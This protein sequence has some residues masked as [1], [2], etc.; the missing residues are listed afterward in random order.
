MT[1]P[2]PKVAVV[3]AGVAGLTAA[4]KLQHDCEVSLFEK[5][6]YIGGHTRTLTV[7]DGPDRGTP[8]D[9]GFIVMNHRN[10]PHFTQLLREWDVELEDSD[11]SFSYHD[12]T[13]GYAYAG[14]GIRGLFPTWHNLV[15][16]PHWKL[17]AELRRFGKI[18]TEALANGSAKTQSLGEFLARH[19]FS[20]HFRDCYLF[21]MGAAIWSS[22]PKKLSEFPAEPY[23]HFFQNHGLLTLKDRPQWRVVRGGSQSYVRKA[24]D[25]LKGEIHIGDSPESIFRRSEGV[26]LCFSDARKLEF[27]HVF[28]GAHADEA[29]ALLG[30]PD[31]EEKTLLGAWTYQPNEVVLH[32][33]ED[34]M[35]GPKPCWASW[36]FAREIGF[37]PTKPVSVSY[38]MNRL[39]NLK[40]ERNY[41]VTLNRLGEIQESQVINRTVLHHPQYT[42]AAMDSHEP[43]R[44]RNGT[45]NTWLVGSYF[46]FGFHEDAVRSAVEATE[47]FKTRIVE[48]S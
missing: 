37:D 16:R 34:V 48:P 42:R 25:R 22:P 40:T 13:Q 19:Q 2:R 11:M 36:N 29:L 17:I 18:G 1:S 47:A 31:E 7:P 12:V 8:V 28:I 38:W 15:S 46:G 43:L 35:P 3:G 30:D 41:F 10:Y 26:T 4:W 44:K 14:T 23:L 21:A 45:R 9:T 33:W 5:N 24:L 6:D 27:D 32:T 39:Q 20:D